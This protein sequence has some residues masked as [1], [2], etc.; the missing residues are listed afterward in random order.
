[1]SGSCIATVLAQLLLV[2]AVF[3]QDSRARVQGLVTDSSN[4]VIAGAAVTLLNNNTGVSTSQQT[5]ASGQYLF[6]LVLP[7]DYSITVENPG[8]RRF[9]QRNILVQSRGDVTVNAALDVGSAA[10]SVTVEAAPVAVQFNTSTMALTI[11]TKMANELPI[12]HRNPFLLVSLNPATTIRSTTEQSPFHHWAATQ[13]DVGGNTST[14]NDILLDGAPSMASEKSSYTP[15]VDAVQE[16]HV[17][18][19]AVDA[20]YGH[21][22]GGILT[23]QMKSGTNNY[24]G[25]AYYL[26]RNPA[27]NAVADHITRRANLTRNHVWGGTLG[28]PVLKNKLFNF[29]SYEAWRTMEPR[30]VAMTLPTD[31]ERTGDFSQSRNIEGGLRTI[32]DPFSTTVVN[33]VISRTPFPG[34]RIPADRIDPVARRMMQDIWKPNGAGEDASGANNFRAG[35]AENIKFWNFSD[36]ADWNISDRLVVFGRF[37]MFKTYVTQADYSGINSLAQQA[38][39]SERH[40]WST[41]G[42]LVYTLNPSTV[43]N[44]RGSWNRVF[45]SFAVASMQLKESDLASLWN[46]NAWYTPYVKRL[47]RFII[48]D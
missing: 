3:A 17:Q 2:S 5:N 28:H 18:Q 33:G 9:V 19:N 34:N 23:V 13:F 7:G 11:N 48:R 42:D 41:V 26:G 22:A 38:N 44:L 21:S 10:E 47:R 37:S 27:I 32:Y 4:A 30:S 14:K 24:H 31:L 36:R 1:M 40:S 29:V 35:F 12:I 20:E 43:L 16:V 25:S 39:G 45:D 46:N 6:D 8:F 15:S